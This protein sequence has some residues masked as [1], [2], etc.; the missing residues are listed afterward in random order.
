MFY[1]K[2]NITL[3]SIVAILL[4][5]TNLA[6]IKFLFSDMKG[7]E[8]GS[9]TDWLSAFAG[10]ISAIGTVATFWIAYKALKKAPEWM[11]QKHYDIAYS[12]IENAVFKDLS[13]VRSSS[14]H[15]KTRIVSLANK[16][17]DVVIGK[18]E[19]SKLV[20][21]MLEGVE[22][23]IDEFHRAAYSII[24]QLKSIERTDYKITEYTESIITV[25]KNAAQEYNALYSRV[26]IAEDEIIT[27]CFADDKAREIYRGETFKI[28]T[29]AI[30]TNKKLTDA[31]NKVFDENRPIKNFISHK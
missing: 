1:R 9:V 5:L 19:K 25:L 13:N 28:Q 30:S 10:I 2:I 22:S 23:N 18:K 6:L 4:F 15:L 16:C 17:K 14:L 7:F 11:A 12:I 29:D 24:N 20:G 21:E 27:H 26:F 3:L 31:I 8:W